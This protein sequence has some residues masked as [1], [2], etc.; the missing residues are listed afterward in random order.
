MSRPGVQ[1]WPLDVIAQLEP[2][3]PTARIR[4]EFQGERPFDLPLDQAA[5]L[6]ACSAP[7]RPDRL[8]PGGFRHDPVTGEPLQPV[9]GEEPAGWTSL[10]STDGLP[11]TPFYDGLHADQ[12]S[13]HQFPSRSAFASAGSPPALYAVHGH[14]GL[15]RRWRRESPERDTDQGWVRVARVGECDLPAWSHTVVGGRHALVVPTDAGP[16]AVLCPALGGRSTSDRLPGPRC[17]AGPVERLPREGAGEFL[18]PAV[19]QG[20]LRLFSRM[21]DAGAGW[22]AAD[23]DGLDGPPPGDHLSA[24]V[25]DGAGRI[26]WVGATGVL[27]APEHESPVWIHWEPGFQ[28]L[29]R[30]RP[31]SDAG[32]LWQLGRVEGPE[33]DSF[34]FRRLSTG[35]AATRR[36]ANPHFSGGP[37]T[38][39][40]PDQNRRFL[41]P[42]DGPE[43]DD[44]LRLRSDEGFLAPL[45]TF[46]GRAGRPHRALLMQVEHPVPTPFVLDEPSGLQVG[47]SLRLHEPRRPIS[48]RLDRGVLQRVEALEDV[49]AVIFGERLHVL[50]R[51]HPSDFAPCVS[52]PV[53]P[54]R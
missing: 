22:T 38:Y 1:Q 54:S 7:G 50:H 11:A 43:P 14:L 19:H 18:V 32:V 30:T 10:C 47:V 51:N 20:R 45:V 16:E 24:P 15:V 35:A 36:T 3:G 21:D 41:R 12:R 44:M 4:V 8:L 6:G 53:T 28:P 48:E 23:V 49:T 2:P 42:W 26:F 9:I 37:L 31:F 40:A 17:V 13:E 39:A 29:R 33:G 34:A 5:A 25:A 27:V 46:L 52:W